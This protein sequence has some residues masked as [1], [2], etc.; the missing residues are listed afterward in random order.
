MK[1]NQREKNQENQRL[2]NRINETNQQINNLNNRIDDKNR[3]ISR[4]KS[5][6]DD[7]SRENRGLQ[8]TIDDKNREIRRLQARIE[9]KNR[10]NRNLQSNFDEYK[11]KEHMKENISDVVFNISKEAFKQHSSRDDRVRYI[12]NYMNDHYGKDWFCNIEIDGFPFISFTEQRWCIKVGVCMNV[13]TY[14]L[15]NNFQKI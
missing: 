13:K 9:D 1:N 3:E 2:N 6:V 8:S 15:S 12:R 7:K 10:E 14:F 4:L 11:R 5:S